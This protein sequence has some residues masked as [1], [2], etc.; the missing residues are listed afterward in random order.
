MLLKTSSYIKWC[1]CE[2]CCRPPFG[3]C[4]RLVWAKRRPG[5]TVWNIWT[6]HVPDLVSRP[7][8]LQSMTVQYT[9]TVLRPLHTIWFEDAY[10]QQSLQHCEHWNTVK[11]NVWNIKRHYH[12]TLPIINLT[13]VIPL[14]LPVSL[15]TFTVVE[16]ASLVPNS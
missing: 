7:V 15:S 4:I 12:L 1:S 13:F 5:L 2:R 9:T 10:V 14:I 16:K 11:Q 8:D 3:T 6:K